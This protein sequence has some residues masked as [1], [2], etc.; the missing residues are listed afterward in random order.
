[1]YDVATF[2]LNPSLDHWS[3][4]EEV[5]PVRKVRTV[6]ERFDPGGGGIN[7]ARVVREL[8]GRPLAVY[9]TGGFAGDAFAALVEQHH[10]DHRAVRISGDTRI[11]HTVYDRANRQEYRFVPEGPRLTE[12]ERE[13][14]LAEIE[15]CE[16]TYA[17]L[18]GSLPA[19]SG[20][21]LA[22]EV[23]R[24][25]R[26]TGARCVADLSGEALRAALDVGVHLVKPNLRELEAL[27]GRDLPTRDDRR[28][29]CR[30][31]VD[32]GGADTVAL[33]LG[34][35]GAMLA[36]ADGVLELTNPAVEVRSAV[37][38]GDS[39]VAAMVVALARGRP[40]DEAFS[41]GVA[42]GAAAA[43]TPA[44]ELCRRA[45]VEELFE[46]IVRKGPP[47]RRR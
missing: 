13:A 17:V 1:M 23:V 4:A 7:V 8:G 33:T 44:T 16:A 14:F 38:A 36:T 32:S 30:D 24:R 41:Y 28:G 19:H 12:Q 42:A 9:A 3:E 40:T 29:A 47:G 45:D 31:I 11:S 10:F 21:D 2:T 27:V 20:P 43:M 22:A 34:A 5:V 15:G 18:S 26:K 39:F 46:R 35:E 25:M 6:E 37:G